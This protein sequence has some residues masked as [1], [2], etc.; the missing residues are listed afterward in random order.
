VACDVISMEKILPV[1]PISRA[2]SAVFPLRLTDAD[3]VLLFAFAFLAVGSFQR[4]SD[5]YAQ[6][7]FQA[8][9]SMFNTSEF[10]ALLAIYSVCKS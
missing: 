1:K 4:F 5:A 3:V 7:V 10:L 6:G 2:R 8:F 9:A